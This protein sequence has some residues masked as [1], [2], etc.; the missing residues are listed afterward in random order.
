M[1]GALALALLVGATHLGAGHRSQG[2]AR[3]A[4]GYVRLVQLRGGAGEGPEGHAAVGARAAAERA[5]T[6]PEAFAFQA[7]MSQLMSL[8]VNT[9]YSNRDIFLRELISNA[10]DAIDKARTGSLPATG[11]EGALSQERGFPSTFTADTE[12]GIRIT[13]NVEA[14]TLAIED[15]GVG[16]SRDDLVK[17]LGTVARSGTKAFMQVLATETGSSSL[18]GQ[19]G[20]GFYSAFLVAERV[21]VFTRKAGAPLLKWESDGQGG[22]VIFFF[23]F[24]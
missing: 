8:I 21:T 9:F 6:Q 10:A 7:E 22:G 23:F 4:F 24:D 14:G 2:L 16:M 19:F 1:H 5:G 11:T 3:S 18:I 12:H 15:S 17:F 20:V 13:S